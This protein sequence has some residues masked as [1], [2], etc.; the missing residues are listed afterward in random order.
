MLKPGGFFV[1]GNALP[2]GVWHMAEPILADMGLKSCGAN[3]HTKGAVQARIEDTARVEMFMKH[4]ISYFPAM[5]VPHFGQRCARVTDKMVK[6]FYRHPGT[7]MY[8][9]MV[10]G[11]HSYMHMCYRVPK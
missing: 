6:N 8:E 2:T 7:H 5:N 3:N 1:W 11:E 10:T 9:T 4:L